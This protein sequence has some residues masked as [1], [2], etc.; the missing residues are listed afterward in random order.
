MAQLALRE[1]RRIEA[2]A[3]GRRPPRTCPGAQDAVQATYRQLRITY[4]IAVSALRLH[5][6]L[7]ARLL[8]RRSPSPPPG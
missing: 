5:A 4:R 6:A 3:D 1:L 2:R 8:G 7:S